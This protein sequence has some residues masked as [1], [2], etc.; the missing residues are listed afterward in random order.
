MAG[1]RSLSFP[2][3][4]AQRL[5]RWSMELFTE[6]LLEGETFE[7]DHSF[8]PPGEHSGRLICRKLTEEER[9]VIMSET[10]GEWMCSQYSG[11]STASYVSGCG[12]F[13]DN[14]QKVIEDHL[15]ESISEILRSQVSE[16][17]W[18]DLIENDDFA[19]FEADLRSHILDA[20]Q[21]I[22]TRD[23]YQWC[24]KEV[25]WRRVQR[26]VENQ[27]RQN[28]LA[29]CRRRASAF[30]RRYLPWLP[31]GFIDKPLWRNSRIEEQLREALKKAD[32]KTLEA[33]KAVGLKGH[34]S[35]S[36]ASEIEKVLAEASPNSIN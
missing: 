15:Q 4:E 27:N 1:N 9:R 17:E 32:S 22:P 34:F 23:A 3:T 8:D 20:I 36:V 30:Q 35:N 21:S 19:D 12:L 2:K 26:E 29:E 6:W 28:Y 5:A 11:T 7:V 33:L 24:E 10:L 31:T 13:H 14:Y 25:L 18:W 16:E